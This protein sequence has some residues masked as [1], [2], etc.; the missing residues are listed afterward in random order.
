M[1]HVAHADKKYKNMTAKQKLCI[2]NKTY[3]AYRMYYLEHGSMPDDKAAYEIH[4]RLFQIVVSLAPK[5]LFEEFE[6]ICQKRIIKSKYEE[7]IQTD[8]ANGITLESLKEKK[9]K[10]TPEEKLAIQKKKNAD[11][12]KRREKKKAKAALENYN[13]DQNDNFFFIAGY[14]SG[15]APYG[16]T[17]EEMGLN[18][19]ES[20][21][22]EQEDDIW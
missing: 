4:R 22:D 16:V 20:L 19:C 15:G 14:T 2:A 12:R 1:K 6:A 18:P 5:T 7:R 10:K 13:P 11:R 8:I 17:W 9:R 3:D 21:D